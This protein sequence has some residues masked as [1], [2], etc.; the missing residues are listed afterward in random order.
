MKKQSSDQDYVEM[1][2]QTYQ[3]SFHAFKQGLAEAPS[4][5]N[6]PYLLAGLSLTGA[7]IAATLLFVS[8]MDAPSPNG[9]GDAPYILEDEKQDENSVPDI[10]EKVEFQ[11][12][13]AKEAIERGPYFLSPQQPETIHHNEFSISTNDDWE[14]KEQEI[15]KGTKT[16]LIGPNSQELTVLLLDDPQTDQASVEIETFLNEHPYTS[17]TELPIE[18]VR[19][20]VIDARVLLSFDDTQ[21][22]FDDQAYMYSFK[23]D[24]TNRLFD[25]FSSEMYGKRLILFTDF[26]LDEPDIWAQA[27]FFMTRVYPAESTYVLS[28]SEEKGEDGRALTKDVFTAS[29]GVSSSYYRRTTV[30]WYE[31]KELG[32]STYIPQNAQVE[33]VVH[34]GMMEWIVDVPEEGPSFYSFGKIDQ[35]IAFNDIKDLFISEYK[36]DEKSVS[37]ENENP[38]TF[39]YYTDEQGSGYVNL[40]EFKGSWYFI[41]RHNSSEEVP[42]DSEI[43]EFM[44]M[45][46]YFLDELVWNE[47]QEN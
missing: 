38:F 41:H 25:I 20:Y 5:K 13:F 32:F 34:N 22:R 28:T 4:R 14:I 27:Y 10:L 23:N 29:F 36:I 40:V 42:E 30:E 24:E 8:T 18:Q 26:P 21:F 1:S 44:G 46:S 12:E 39:N 19:E 35:T 17:S 47:E 2:D 9:Q 31:N 6:K 43:R 11:D 45:P 7:A 33:K 37:K 3:K 16:T 15:P